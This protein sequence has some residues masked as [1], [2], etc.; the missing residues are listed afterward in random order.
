MTLSG[1]LIALSGLGLDIQGSRDG[2]AI[3]L[4]TVALKDW[5]VKGQEPEAGEFPDGLQAVTLILTPAIAASDEPVQSAGEDKPQWL[6]ECSDEKYGLGDL[7]ETFHSLDEVW[8][9]ANYEEFLECSVEATNPD[10]Y[11]PTKAEKK[12]IAIVNEHFDGREEDHYAYANALEECAVPRGPKNSAEWA[13]GVQK[14]LE[15]AVLVCP[16]AK[17]AKEMTA[18]AR[19]EKFDDGTYV[20][21]KTIP[22]GAYQVQLGKGSN[23]LH[24]CYWSRTNATGD[25]IANNFIDFAPQSPVVQVY[26]GEGFVSEG[27]GIWAKVG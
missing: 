11:K 4:G 6:F 16:D 23:G 9:S 13:G 1:A 10:S 27:C 24:D 5:T 21:G 20:V 17:H 22:A 15:A 26:A 14:F 19:G 8:A 2:S 7:E 3:D 12:V 18:W 25:I